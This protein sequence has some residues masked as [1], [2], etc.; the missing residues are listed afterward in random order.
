MDTHNNLY[1]F[2]CRHY[3][4]VI[5]VGMPGIDALDL[6]EKPFFSTIFLLIK[7]HSR[8]KTNLDT[9]NNLYSFCYWHENHVLHIRIHDIDA[10]DLQEELSFHHFPHNQSSSINETNLDT[11][12]NRYSFCYWHDNRVLFIETH[13]SDASDLLEKILFPPFSL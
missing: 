11:H 13:D 2:H 7:V 12:N 3:N 8:K 10:L 1:S 4:D 5:H 6:Q 9:N